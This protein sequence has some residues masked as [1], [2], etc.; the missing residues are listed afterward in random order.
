ME[1]RNLNRFQK[2]VAVL[3][4]NSTLITVPKFSFALELTE[5]A[6]FNRCFSHITRKAP[7][8]DNRFLLDVIENK[9]TGSQACIE[10]LN[11][12][13]LASNNTISN[14]NDK[15]AKDI[16]N[17]FYAVHSAWFLDQS[18]VG[19]PSTNIGLM[20]SSSG[21][22][23]YTKAL[24]D[25]SFNYQD[26][27]TNQNTFEGIR[28]GGL[29][30]VSANRPK[31]AFTIGRL[32]LNRAETN[33][34]GFDVYFDTGYE[35][36]NLFFPQTGD[37][38]GIKNETPLIAPGY[39]AV[40]TGL[41]IKVNGTW[42][43]G[44]LGHRDYLMKTV[45]ATTINSDGGIHMPRRYGRAIFNDFVCRDLPVVDIANDT[46][47][48]V[49]PNS[50]VTFRTNKGCVSCH[51]S[52]DQVSGILRQY[53]MV[54][55]GV[56]RGGGI[57]ARAQIERTPTMSSAYSWPPTPDPDY[58]RKTRLGKFVYRTTDGVLVST[59]ID[60]FNALGNVFKN[61]DDTYLCTASRYF[62]HF[63]NI[64]YPVTK[65]PSG[66]INNDPHAKFIKDLAGV[67]KSTQSSFKTVETIINS[68][69]YRDSNFLIREK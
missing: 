5:V 31:S 47:P 64:H 24:F 37:L 60:G 68:D 55:L 33:R 65:I 45:N 1:L 8:L 15:I 23:Y 12:A 48:Y 3:I 36:P 58:F 49:N 38:I 59:D 43:G 46:T 53:N 2:M 21:S 4:I 25:P 27:F 67:L 66:I 14:P 19:A 22:L 26:I 29:P 18:I 34:Q 40:P 16:L 39:D 56:S 50:P 13:K 6:L 17:T 7:T 32:Q 69:I 63:T 51:V 62:K 20:D 52:M 10:V 54:S 35:W 57:T 42:G 44:I 11:K 41:N 28:T 61:L 30:E 9:K